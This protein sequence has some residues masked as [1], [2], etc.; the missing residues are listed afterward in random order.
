MKR[1]QF[2]HRQSS[3]FRRPGRIQRPFEPPKGGTLTVQG[4]HARS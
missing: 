2:M 4:F 1:D 3:A